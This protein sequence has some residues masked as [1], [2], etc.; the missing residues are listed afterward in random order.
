VS[1]KPAALACVGLLALLV[2]G[3]GSADRVEYERQLAA[4][5]RIVD[6]SLAQLPTDD[7]STVGPDEVRRIAGDLR[8]AAD[9]LD[10]LNPPEDAVDAQER[11]ERGMRGV[12]EAFETLAD[13]LSGAGT[14]TQKAEL[15]VRFATDEQV[16]AAFDDLVGAQEAYAEAG[17]RVFGAPSQPA[18]ASNVRG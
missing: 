15:F 16:D 3:C 9:R 1:K 2:A 6:R 13:D 10:D 7:A 4:V 11:L 12:A 5:G 8:E 14:D 18:A 17:Y